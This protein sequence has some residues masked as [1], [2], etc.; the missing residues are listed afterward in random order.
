MLNVNSTFKKSNPSMYI[1]KYTIR[2]DSNLF[3]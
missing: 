1:P 2:Y 3:I